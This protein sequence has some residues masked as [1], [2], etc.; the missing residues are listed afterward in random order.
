MAAAP[1]NLPIPANLLRPSVVTVTGISKLT[2][3]FDV[4]P[5]FWILVSVRTMGT[6]TYVGIGDNIEQNNRLFAR[7]DFQLFDVPPGYWFDAAQMYAVADVDG[8]VLLEV[9]GAYPQEVSQFSSPNAG[10]F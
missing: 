9:S 4:L 5:A 7:T 2:P 10:G 3:L 8:Q 1:S 6:A